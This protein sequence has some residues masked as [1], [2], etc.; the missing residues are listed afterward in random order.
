MK[1]ISLIVGLSALS[2]CA[3]QQPLTMLR[4]DEI[5][6]ADFVEA[7][8]WKPLFKGVQHLELAA[9]APRK[10]S[11]HAIRVDFNNLSICFRVTR[12]NK[13]GP[14]E[15][16]SITTSHFLETEKLSVAINGAPFAPIVNEEGFAQDIIGL[17]VSHGGIVSA[18]EPGHG[19]LFLREANRASISLQDSYMRIGS[20]E[21]AVGGNE[22]DIVEFMNLAPEKEERPIPRSAVGL[23]PDC[24]HLILLV[25]DGDQPGH[26]L[27]ATRYDAADWL[28]KLGCY[29]GLNLDSGGSTTL[30]ICEADGRPRVLNRPIHNDV[31]GTE[32]PCPNHLGIIAEPLP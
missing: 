12:P 13:E 21:Y 1:I 15:A 9:E 2:N 16:D 23:D 29:S 20:V 19:A 25:I 28:I 31:A 17:A 22:I 27:G 24:S 8:A 6:I 26:S 4:I 11:G 10:M 18:P 32:R 14:L 7:E 5:Q 3:V 30:V